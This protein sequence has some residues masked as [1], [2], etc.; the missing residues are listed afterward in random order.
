MVGLER[1]EAA[2]ENPRGDAP[3]LL[4]CDHASNALP[5][6]LAGLGLSPA[7]RADHVAWDIG[8]HAL[9][10][11]LAARLDAALVAAPASRLIIDPNRAL[12]ASDLIP[13]TA[14]GVPVSGNVN[15][16]QE[17]RRARVNAL[18]APYHDAIDALLKAR[19]D[20]RAIVSIHSFTPVLFGEA[21]PWHA[22]I[23][24]GSDA[25]IADVLIEAL[26]REPELTIGRNQP[27]A[28][29]QGV[30]YTL[31][32]HGRGRATA[33]IEV[34]NDLIRDEA[35]QESWARRLA[36]A[37]GAALAALLEADR[38]AAELGGRS[39]YAT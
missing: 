38:S 37:L 10:R 11:R 33:M 12:D 7:Q 27:Y 21:R 19:S 15:L 1:M 14:D 39:T 6:V 13:E 18:H 22:G 29:E 25:R 3:V 23:L 35:G 20:I 28:P 30:F 26:S 24:H 31:D 17:A 4:V 2:V 34:R 16:S 36:G 5:D 9:A 8:A 32:R